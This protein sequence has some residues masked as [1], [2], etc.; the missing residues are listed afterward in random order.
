MIGGGIGLEAARSEIIRRGIHINKGRLGYQA[1][2]QPHL[3][4]TSR[5]TVIVG[6]A[7]VTAGIAG[8]D[9]AHTGN[10]IL[11]VCRA[12]DQELRLDP[13]GPP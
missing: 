11:K 1:E 3:R 6:L 10:D 2:D 13:C 9:V 8:S 12:P 4:S 7:G 5:S